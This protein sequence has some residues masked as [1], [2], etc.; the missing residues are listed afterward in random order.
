MYIKSNIRF[1]NNDI[2]IIKKFNPNVIIHLAWSG[3]PK[4]NTV[5]SRKSFKDSKI[6]FDNILKFTNIKKIISLGS[7]LEYQKKLGQKKI[8]DAIDT[9]SSFGKYKNELRLYLEN[10]CRSKKI[11]LAWLRVFYLYGEN[12][13]EKSLINYILSKIKKGGVI[14]FKNPNILND[15]IYIYDFNNLIFK[16]IKKKKFFGIYNVGTSQA[17][18]PLQI[19]SI[20]KSILIKKNYKDL[21]TKI[22]KKKI[23]F[24][25]NIYNTKKTFGWK[26]SCTIFQGIKKLLT[27]YR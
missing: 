22:N 2:E 27:Q 9:K 10:K 16:I 12:Q 4:L 24:T 6:F 14:K 23:F 7:C 26:P 1:I 11:S 3:I 15:Y 18:S 13:R 5:N 20:I 25:A 21:F 17:Y 8:K 19:H